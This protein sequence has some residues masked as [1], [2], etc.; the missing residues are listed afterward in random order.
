MRISEFPGGKDLRPRLIR[1]RRLA[2]LYRMVIAFSLFSLPAL[3]QTIYPTKEVTLIVPFAAGGP[4]DMVARIVSYRM[5]QLLGQQ[6]VVENIVGTGGTTAAIRAKRSA[7]D[8]YTILMGHMGTHAAALALNPK[9]P[10]SPTEDFEPIGLTASMPVLILARKGFPAATL[11][12][13][14]EYAQH[15]PGKITMAHAGV[16]SVSFATCEMLSSLTGIQPVLVAFQGTGPAINALAKGHVD[17]LC[18]QIVNVVPQLQSGTVRAFA[19]GTPRRSPA[20]PDVPTSEEAGLP[21]FR[22]S[23]WN[24]L[25]APKRTPPDIIEKLSSALSQ[26]LDDD[27]TRKQ[28][29][30]LGAD[31]PAPAERTPQALSELVK[32]EIAKWSIIVSSRSVGQQPSTQTAA[33]PALISAQPSTSR[34]F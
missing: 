22:A 33:S 18:D 8:G 24:A 16:G 17:Y 13:F 14:I 2:Q 26:A 34:G 31:L 25:F 10:Y 28:L 1:R 27:N 21:D 23:A 29:L 11:A 9:L 5:S 4:T 19:I 12:E 3:A 30:A 7:P 32:S 20:L 15:N 6:I